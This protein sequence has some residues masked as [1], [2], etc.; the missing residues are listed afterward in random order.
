M[1]TTAPISS[2]HPYVAHVRLIQKGSLARTTKSTELN[3]TSSRSHAVLTLLLKRSLQDKVVVS[4]LHFVDLAGSERLK[5]T[6]VAGE[7]VRESISINSGLLALGNVISALAS[8]NAPNNNAQQ[9]VP[10]RDSKL[11]RLLQDSLG[12][13]SRTLMI[14]CVSASS[15]DLVESVNTLRYAHRAR[16]IRNQSRVNEHANGDAFELMQLRKQVAALR[17]ELLDLRTGRHSN[18]SD[19]SPQDLEMAVDWRRRCEQLEREKTA[20]QQE[21][22]ALRALS[23][24]SASS[25][26]KRPFLRSSRVLVAS[27]VTNTGVPSTVRLPPHNYSPKSPIKRLSV[28]L[29][30]NQMPG[31]PSVAHW[32]QQV[33]V[34]VADAKRRLAA[35]LTAVRSLDDV[36]T[37]DDAGQ[38][39]GTTDEVDLVTQRVQELLAPV[40][41]DLA[42][43]S[44]LIGKIEAGQREFAALRQRYDERLHLATVQLVQLRRERDD[45]LRQLPNTNANANTNTNA[46]QHHPTPSHASNAHSQSVLLRQKYEERIKQLTRD[47]ARLQEQVDAATKPRQPPADPNAMRALRAEVRALKEER[48]RLQELLERKDGSLRSA[49]LASATDG[50]EWRARERRAQE[51][52]T[53]WR[54]AYEF[55]RTLLQRRV[56]QFLQAKAKIRQLLHAMRRKH[57]N[58][59]SPSVNVNL[60]SPG[61]RAL[62]STNPPASTSSISYASTISNWNQAGNPQGIDLDLDARGATTSNGSSKPS[63]P[64]VDRI[65]GGRRVTFAEP[66][67]TDSDQH[68]QQQHGDRGMGGSN[69][70]SVFKDGHGNRGT[71]L[72]ARL[73]NA[74]NLATLHHRLQQHPRAIATADPDDD[75]DANDKVRLTEGNVTTTTMM[76][77]VD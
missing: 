33:R 66:L 37:P 11:T 4:K 29:E 52:A 75:D 6:N 21:L 42:F 20:L 28:S 19:N 27:A 22:D 13:N 35:R 60:Q 36:A 26:S 68:H 14:A 63:S 38:D 24:T 59:Q 65:T 48:G 34:F 8:K 50:Q 77:D 10:Y 69:D 41:E 17:Q 18:F 70:E 47:N 12:G 49:S 51:Q 9:H 39:E 58:L 67:V 55:E 32:T 31:S 57:V 72:L 76:M 44:D 5:R 16:T 7:R 15:E 1:P 23:T 40:K 61:W 56:E 74:A 62:L 53:K 64:L 45:A 3:L 54:K 71:N 46:N 25:A 2:I 30:D 43:K 73:A